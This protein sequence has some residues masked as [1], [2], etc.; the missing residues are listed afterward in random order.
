MPRSHETTIAIDAPIEEVWAALTEVAQIVRW[1]APKVTVEPRVGG[2]MISHWGPGMDW[3]TTVEIWDPGCHLRL[4]ET[5]DR[6]ISPVEHK[7][8]PCTLKQD[9]Y[10][11]TENGKTIL[12]L[13]HSGFGDDEDWDLEYDGTRGGWFSC[14]FR[15]QQTLERH[16]GE[17]AY[18]GIET[19]LIR[20]A[21]WRE[22]L[23]RFESLPTPPKEI[24]YR[25]PYHLG[26]V[27]PEHNHSI[28]TLSVQ[29]NEAGAI[30]Y[31]EYLFYNQPPAEASSVVNAVREGLRHP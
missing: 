19:L 30:A 12:R 20:G 22:V 28:L 29:P 6:M 10:L 25:K 13:V 9:F 18:N 2:R 11:E 17:A 31:F 24:A 5:R 1:F 16:R 21:G 23:A 3:P 15:L 7:M 26:A 14:L 27:L 4:S 8:S